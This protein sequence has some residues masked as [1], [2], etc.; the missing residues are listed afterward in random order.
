MALESSKDHGLFSN[1]L[2]G[3]QWFPS[4]KTN[5]QRGWNVCWEALQKTYF[6]KVTSPY[7]VY[8]GVNSINWLRTATMKSK[9]VNFC[10][11]KGFKIY[12]WEPLSTYDNRKNTNNLYT[13][14][15]AND[16]EFIRAKEFDSIHEYVVRNKLKN[17]D[18]YCPSYKCK[19]YLQKFYPDIK[20]NCTPV[21]WIYPATINVMQEE[22]IY[23]SQAITKKFWCG[24]WRYASHR[25][26]I[27]S[28]LVTKTDSYNVS[29]LYNS[30]KDILLKN[31]FTDKLPCKETLLIG[32]D[33]LNT[34]A[35]V[36]MDTPI[37]EKL[38]IDEYIDIHIDTNPKQ[39]YAECFC[40][41]VNETRYAEP[42][43]LLTEKIM[44]AMLNYRP[45]IMV[46]PPG[47]LE[48]MRAW[49]FQTFSDWFDESY[50]LEQDH[51]KRME[52]IFK[53]I[54]W[55]NGKSIK[56]LKEMYDDMLPTLLH[57]K[58][59]IEELQEMLL[60]APITKN[61]IYKRIRS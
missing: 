37:S 45:V 59:W 20:I 12:L 31:S 54:D 22:G 27:A 57:N 58:V 11:K 56:E 23:N 38:S 15:S 3:K 4:N 16:S 10:N 40:A 25:H 52:K 34:M 46:G 8:F 39:S 1:I 36:T 9:E 17:V 42:T 48:Y 2:L 6:K 49:G 55:I 41:I 14:W 18:V 33:K 19:T 35:P 29:W 51:A 60:Q 5:L 50:D 61:K 21:G 53:L 7:A 30:S 32:A 13:N 47:N 24:N 44:N 43:G 28:Y 26:C